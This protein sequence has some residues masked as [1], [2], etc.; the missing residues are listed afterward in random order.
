MVNVISKIDKLIGHPLKNVFRIISSKGFKGWEGIH[1][2]GLNR[3]EEDEGLWYL[4]FLTPA[5]VL[6]T[7]HAT[8]FSYLNVFDNLDKTTISKGM[9]FYKNSLQ[10]VY[11]ALG[12]DG[13][14][15]IKSVMSSGRLKSIKQNFP[16]ARFIHVKRSIHKTLP[17]Y[18]SMFSKSWNLISPKTDLKEYKALGMTA[19]DFY[20]HTSAHFD[21]DNAYII[22]Y[23]DLIERPLNVVMKLLNDL[24]IP[25]KIKN[26]ENL[27][28]ELK[29]ASKYKSK[30]I[31]SLEGYGWKEDEINK[32]I[33]E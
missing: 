5:I 21:W 27:K 16:Q 1:P 33:L 28:H 9:K 18:T 7:P 23:Q 8:E 30:N 32:L 26:I 6:F 24:M 3:N 4:S 25:D 2:T 10:R 20:N 29:N 11:Y 22:L 15:L 14:F 17:S 12:N 31:Y 13:V 19:I